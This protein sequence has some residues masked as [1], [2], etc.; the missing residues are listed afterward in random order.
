MSIISDQSEREGMSCRGKGGA[1]G[2]SVELGNCGIDDTTEAK[3]ELKRM[4]E[5]KFDFR[6]RVTTSKDRYD[7]VEY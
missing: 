3:E 5:R 7:E 1:S 6:K 2:K 4:E